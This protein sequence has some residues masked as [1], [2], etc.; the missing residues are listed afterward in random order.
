MASSGSY[1]KLVPKY[2]KFIVLEKISECK[3]SINC[4]V[5]EIQNAT[6]HLE[7]LNGMIEMLEG[8]HFTLE[9]YDSVWCLREMVKSE[10]KK[11]LDLKKHLVV[12]EEDIR[13]FVDRN[14]IDDLPVLE[15]V[16]FKIHKNE[17]FKLDPLSILENKWALFD[18]LPNKS[19]EKGLKLIHTDNDV[20]SFFVDVERR[21]KIHL[22]VTHNQQ[23]LGKFY[24]KNMVWLEE[25]ASLCCS[26]SSLFSTRIKRKS[27]KTTK[28]CGR[29]NSKGKEKMVDDEPLGRKLLKTSRKEKEKMDEFPD[30]TPIKER[31]YCDRV[32]RMSMQTFMN[33]LG[34]FPDLTPTK[35]REVDDEAVV[36]TN[37]RRAIINGKAKMVE[38][39]DVQESNVKTNELLENYFMFE[40]HYDGVFSKYPL[41]YEHG[42]TLTLKLS[43]SNKMLFSKMLD[44]LSYKLECQ[45]WAIF[46]C[47]PRCSLG[48]GLTIVEDDGDME[49]LYAIAKK[50]GLVNFYIAHIPENLVEYYF[51]ILTLDA[52]DEEV[53]SK[54]KS[55]EKRKLDDSAMSPH[56]LVEW[57]EQEAGSP[58][59]RTPPIKP[60]RKGIEFPCKNLFGDFF[61]HCDSVADEI[62]LHDNWK[63]EG[64]SLD[65]HIDVG[66]PTT[67]CDLVHECVVENG[68]SLP[69]MDKECFSNN[70][71]LDDVVHANRKSMPLLLM[72]KGRNKVSVTRKSRCRHNSKTFRLRKGFGKRVACGA[73]TR[74]L[75]GLPSL[76]VHVVDEVSQ[77]TKQ[78][79]L[80]AG[81]SNTEDKYLGSMSAGSSN[82]DDRDLEKSN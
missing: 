50:Y 59:L 65:G 34:E 68:D 32:G 11:L 63:Y 82:T 46:V 18:C 10:N 54:V 62:V 74:R 80:S 37:Y 24:L 79:S 71:V 81:S 4:I 78:G 27:H 9:I 60:R 29:E 69:I 36:V 52:P 56:E 45:I 6:S 5:G 13:G 14:M 48:E 31:K 25:D 28:E 73:N 72:K 64:L 49:K 2:I 12:A 17:Y 44:M 41:R 55:H 76:N 8:M 20:H 39:A 75:G 67:W 47:S 51:K 38:V 58:Y 61:L 66:G 53:K 26:S 7:H 57:A 22:Y 35:E 40:V 1:K 77:V 16:V 15:E 23:A 30:S 19:L 33:E 42:K 21:G 70:V 43:K 3:R